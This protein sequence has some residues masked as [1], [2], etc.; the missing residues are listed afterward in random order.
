MGDKLTEAEIAE[1]LSENERLKA[2]LRYYSGGYHNERRDVIPAD[3][4]ARYGKPDYDFVTKISWI[5]RHWFFAGTEAKVSYIAKT[6]KN[7]LQKRT[8]SRVISIDKMSEEQYALYSE[9]FFEIMKV[10]ENA[11]SK[12]KGEKA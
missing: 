9:A 5:I 7:G 8:A 4:L 6:H 10:L 11:K 1:I 12:I 2:S 3:V